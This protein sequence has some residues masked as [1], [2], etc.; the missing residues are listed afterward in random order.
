MKQSKKRDQIISQAVRLFNESGYHDT[1]LQDIADELG[2]VKTSISYHFHSKEA[3][4]EEVLTRSLAFTDRELD[5]AEQKSNGLERVLFLI[6]DRAAQ[7]A[8]ALAGSA[9]PLML[10]SDLETISDISSPA[11]R[12]K[13]DHHIQ[14]VCGF[15]TEGCKDG[16]IDVLSPEAAT[17]FV[18]NILHWLPGWLANI[19]N[20][21]HSSSIDGLCDLLRNGI[22]Q[23]PNRPPQRLIL[24]SQ[25]DEYPAIFDRTVRNKLKRDAFLRTGTRFLNRQGYRNLSLNDV[26]KELGVTRG[27]FYYYIADK[28]ALIESCFERTCETIENAI[29]TGKQ[30]NPTDS[31]G[32]IEHVLYLLFEGYITGLNPLTRLNL[33]NSVAPMKRIAIEAKL[34]RIRASFGEIIADAIVDKSAR[35]LDLDALENLLMGSIFAASQWRLSATPLTQSWKPSHEPLAA[36]TAYFQPLLTGLAPSK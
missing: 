27:A 29:E 36:S 12:E 18:M 31:L 7:H 11:L 10:L 33:L 14:R 23:S 16:S 4:L 8:N 13:L 2:K 3:L 15:I 9:P 35:P 17:F 6:R 32:V 25:S 5:S 34:K 19:P 1:R 26:A 21:R 30:N 28:D 22:A 20:A 24:R